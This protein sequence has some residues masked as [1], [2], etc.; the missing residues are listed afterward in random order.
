MLESHGLLIGG[1][2]AVTDANVVLGRIIP[3]YF[4]Q[5]FGPNEDQPI[6]IAA[7]KHAFIDLTNEV[8]LHTFM[9]LIPEQPVVISCYH[10]HLFF[11]FITTGYLA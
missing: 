3:R 11:P 5:I 6:D 4:P 2:L 1:P 9:S 7:S 8:Q 10:G